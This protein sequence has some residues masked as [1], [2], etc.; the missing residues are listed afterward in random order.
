M[1][2]SLKSR[3]VNILLLSLISTLDR[4]ISY[5]L[6]YCIWLLKFLLNRESRSNS[7]GD[8]FAPLHGPKLICEISCSF[9]YSTDLCASPWLVLGIFGNTAIGVS[10]ISRATLSAVLSA[11]ILL[12]ICRLRMLCSP[13]LLDMRCDDL[14]TLLYLLS[15][16]LAGVSLPSKL[17]E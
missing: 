14:N 12:S 6:L 10:C 7:C 4:P 15:L 2:C 16:D 1:Y 5:V 9:C 3:L 11:L 8:E 13:T 17:R